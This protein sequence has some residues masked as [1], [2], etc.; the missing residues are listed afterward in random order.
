M[1]INKQKPTQVTTTHDYQHTDDL[2]SSY[3]SSGLVYGG[4]AGDGKWDNENDSSDVH[5]FE[6]NSSNET[7]DTSGITPL[8]V[9]LDTFAG[10]TKTG[11]TING[12]SGG[13][14]G[15][16][17]TYSDRFQT[18]YA[19]NNTDTSNL[20]GD[21]L[22]YHHT[23]S[24]LGWTNYNN[25]TPF[26]NANPPADPDST[27]TINPHPSSVPGAADPH[28]QSDAD[29]IVSIEQQAS[30]QAGLINLVGG[31]PFVIP[32]K[33]VQPPAATATTPPATNSTTV[34]GSINPGGYIATGSMW[35]E[36]ANSWDFIKSLPQATYEA[37]KAVSAD[38]A[39]IV[40]LGL[41]DQLRANSQAAWEELVL[42]SSWIDGY[43][44]CSLIR[45]S[46]VV[47]CQSTLVAIALR[48]VSHA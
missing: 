8:I 15:Y 31:S 34:K 43:N 16:G 29:W 3:D 35:D 14:V 18:H 12:D 7:I 28:F 25:G 21:V 42:Y 47:N 10:Y 5:L 41:N 2:T 13:L 20:G 6:K 9:A 39:N 23:R 48:V 30:A 19:I 44:F 33:I 46:A 4:T 38:L 45:A 24:D 26:P 22:T 17:T 40:T 1:K 11:D 36:I 32:P 27:A 37:T